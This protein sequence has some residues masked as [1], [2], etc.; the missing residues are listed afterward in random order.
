ME[1]LVQHFGSV[2]FFNKDIAVGSGPSWRSLRLC[3]NSEGKILSILRVYEMKELKS[4][5]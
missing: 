3:E 2:L 5:G 4:E 1:N